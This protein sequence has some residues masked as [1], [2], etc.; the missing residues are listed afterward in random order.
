[1]SSYIQGHNTLNPGVSGDNSVF[2]LVN[3]AS[4]LW[5][6]FSLLI[7]NVVPIAS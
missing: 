1:M 6:N 3:I 4:R 2:N 5:E 7:S